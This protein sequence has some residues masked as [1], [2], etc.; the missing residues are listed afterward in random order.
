LIRLKRKPKNIGLFITHSSILVLLAAGLV[1]YL[2]KIDGNLA[3]TEGST[4]DLMQSFHNRVIEVEPLNVVG[5]RS[6]SV[7]HDKD[8]SS[9]TPS[10]PSTFK[11]PDMPFDLVVTRYVRHSD[12]VEAAREAP[13]P[14]SQAKVVDGFWL[15]S[16]TPLPENEQNIEG[17]EVLVKPRN[18]GNA[19]TV[20][21]WGGTNNNALV[22][23]DGKDYALRI[24]RQKW[25]LPFAITLNE[26][27]REVY[28]GTNKPR[29]FSSLVT[30]NY[31]DKKE[32][33]EIT[34]NRPL[35]SDGYAVFQ[36]SF[37]MQQAGDRVIKTSVFQVARNPSDH[38]PLI[39]FSLV[40]IGL[41]IH[42]VM[43]LA[44]FLMRPR[45]VPASVPGAAPEPTATPL[46]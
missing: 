39:G 1:E 20:I 11:L 21:L 17:A 42:F 29:R 44:D 5:K 37:D 43:K 14:A 2:Y 15:R 36:S 26:F 13:S 45:P 19:I 33:I 34:M 6:A 8:F 46:P 7:I 9:A 41:L 24:G 10:K 35:R 38:W 31:P 3:V 28:P 22:T 4:T 40:F 30:V 27:I 12:P 18:G 32:D 23:V 16:L 25:Q